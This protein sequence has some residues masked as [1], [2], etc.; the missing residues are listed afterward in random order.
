MN[1]DEDIGDEEDV[2]NVW[3]EDLLQGANE[4]RDQEEDLPFTIA[5]DGNIDFIGPILERSTTQDD[6][7]RVELFDHAGQTGHMV[8]DPH[9]DDWDDYEDYD[10][11]DDDDGGGGYGGGD[12]D[13]IDEDYGYDDYDDEYDDE[14]D[15]EDEDVVSHYPDRRS[16][17]T[18][19][20]GVEMI[21]PRR[22]FRGAKNIETV[23]DC[24]FLLRYR[25]RQ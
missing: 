3:L 17:E 5:A 6:D 22:M 4:D 25:N 20:G 23:K 8:D 9:A 11:Y 1:L 24:V 19:F 12:Y 21:L 2:P 7:E 18:E 13:D 16:A 14:D 15:D 10:D